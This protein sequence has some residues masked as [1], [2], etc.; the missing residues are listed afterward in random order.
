MRGCSL[1][2]GWWV[3]VHDALGESWSHLRLGDLVRMQSVRLLYGHACMMNDDDGLLHLLDNDLIST[4]TKRF[5]VFLLDF[6]VMFKK[7]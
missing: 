2:M 3:R 1:G 5:S 6:P 4:L 7:V